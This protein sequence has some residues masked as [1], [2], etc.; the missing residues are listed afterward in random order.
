MYN[1]NNKAKSISSEV[2]LDKINFKVKLDNP[3][4]QNDTGNSLSVKNANGKKDVYFQNKGKKVADFFLGFFGVYFVT[5]ILGFIDEFIGSMDLELVKE[6]DFIISMFIQL[7]GLIGLIFSG[8]YFSRKSRRYIV[9]GIISMG[10][11]QFIGNILIMWIFFM[12]AQ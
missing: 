12:W 3:V 6:S 1:L 2:D 10:I 4:S 8:V 11:I 9:I 5:F 7:I